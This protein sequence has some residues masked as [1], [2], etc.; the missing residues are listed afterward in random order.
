MEQ[1]MKR[2][3]VP[4]RKRRRIMKGKKQKRLIEIASY[5]EYPLP[6]YWNGRYWKR[7]H[8]YGTPRRAKYVRR[9]CNRKVRKQTGR[10]GNGGNYK[11]YSEFLYDIW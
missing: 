10:I 7:L 9:K 3:N 2:I 4:V 5:T 1:E 6:L 8:S 11:K